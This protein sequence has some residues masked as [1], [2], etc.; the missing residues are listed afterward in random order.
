[1]ALLTCLGKIGDP[2][3]AAALTNHL[4]SSYFVV[5]QAAMAAL[6]SFGPAGT[7]QLIP[8]LSFN[9][10][11]IEALKRD[12]CNK[13]RPEFQIRA[14]N[15]LGGL[16]DHRAVPL[17]KE[18]IEVGPPDIQDAAIQALSQIGCAAWGRCCALRVLAE[19]GDSVLVPVLLPSFEDHSD[20]V[21]LEAVRAL[22]K[23]GGSLAVKHLVRAAKADTAPEA[24]M[25]AIRAL[26]TI[27]AGQPG[28]LDAA[29]RGLK[30]ESRDVRVQAARLLGNFLDKKSIPPL[31]HAVADPRWIV[32]ESAEN[33]LLN[34]GREVVPPLIETLEK[35]S[36]R[37]RFRAAR[38][39]GELNDRRAVAPLKRL[40]SR[41][42]ERKKV[43]E[44]AKASL[45]KLNA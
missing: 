33:A 12:A 36:W 37:M 28:V 42:G 26:R 3:S 2:K 32:R 44:V 43:R 6:I 19:V 31:I 17:L 10:S 24:R 41:K 40:V 35:A 29:R 45:R 14:I 25:E 23:L 21:R 38:L 22:G 27:G 9:R 4:K 1:M 15:A 20:N 39:L 8:M 5:R 13:E 18:L 30:D 16:E 7:T 34:F 11:S